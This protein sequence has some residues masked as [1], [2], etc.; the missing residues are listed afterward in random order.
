M[1]SVVICSLAVLL[2]SAVLLLLWNRTSDPSHF[3]LGLF[4][5]WLSWISWSQLT[6][7]ASAWSLDLI[8]K[9]LFLWKSSPFLLLMILPHFPPLIANYHWRCG[10]VPCHCMWRHFHCFIAQFHFQSNEK[11]WHS[12]TETEIFAGK[13]SD[14]AHNEWQ[15]N[16]HI[17]NDILMVLKNYPHAHFKLN[18]VR[19][20]S[21]RHQCSSSI[22]IKRSTEWNKI[23]FSVGTH[24]PAHGMTKTTYNTSTRTTWYTVTYVQIMYK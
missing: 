1:L 15:V 11:K 18:F 14:V 19:F 12:R 22:L 17:D 16:F 6:L 23:M 3:M 20:M 13:T 7:N 8:R 9:S 10:K 5:Q 21:Y 2:W 24:S 4:P